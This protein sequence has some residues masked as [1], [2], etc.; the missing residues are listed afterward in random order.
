MIQ[1]KYQI[2]VIFM[3]NALSYL[4]ITIK[5]SIYFEVS[6]KFILLKYS[7]FISCTLTAGVSKPEPEDW[8]APICK[9]NFIGT[10]PHPL[11]HVSSV[12]ALRPT[13]VELSGCNRE[14][15]PTG[16]NYLQPGALQAFLQ[17]RSSS[18]PPAKCL[19][20]A[21]IKNHAVCAQECN[22]FA[23]LGRTNKQR[24]RNQSSVVRTGR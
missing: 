14:V 7:P 12:A 1:E 19:G 8:P 15:C 24:A 4:K 17:R 16:P 2:L 5:I 6:F 10:W 23:L 13:A 9:Y 3:L 21:Y 18:L 22:H 11:S 20:F